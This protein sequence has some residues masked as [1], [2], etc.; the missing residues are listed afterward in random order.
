MMHEVADNSADDLTKLTPDAATQQDL[1]RTIR[2]K[3]GAAYQIESNHV[4]HLRG[5]G[6]ITPP[7]TKVRTI[8]YGSCSDEAS[9]M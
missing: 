2:E 5:G 9:W 7:Y 3:S 1:S 8:E 6:R 4:E